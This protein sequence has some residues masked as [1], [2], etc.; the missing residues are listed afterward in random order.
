MR[1]GWSVAV[2]LAACSTGRVEPYT[3]G[4]AGPVDVGTT[5]PNDPIEPGDPPTPV[6]SDDPTDTSAPLVLGTTL[7]ASRQY[8]CA[9]LADGELACWG[10]NDDGQARPPAGDFLSVA[11]AER[12]ACAIAANGGL[13]C[14]GLAEGGRLAPPEGV[15]TALAAGP[16][17]V[18][19]L[20]DDGAPS[21]WGPSA[22]TASPPP[23]NRIAV[24]STFFCGVT[25]TGASVVCAGTGTA[26]TAAPDTGVFK[27][28][29]AGDD[30]VCA[31]EADGSPVCWGANGVGQARP[32]AG[33]FERIFAGGDTSCGI[34]SDG[35]VRCWGRVEEGQDEVPAGVDLASVAPGVDHACGMDTAGDVHCWGRDDRF[36]AT[37]PVLDAEQVSLGLG[38]FGCAVRA[39]G[40]LI[41]FGPATNGQTAPPSGTYVR[42]GVGETHACAV[43]S[44][45]RLACW[46]DDAFGQ[47]TPPGSAGW[48]DVAATKQT[49]CG[50]AGA[51]A[52]VSCWGTRAL[53]A[54]TGAHSWVDGGDFHYVAVKGDGKLSD[55]GAN[56]DGQR[57]EDTNLRFT[58]VSA[59][60][61]NTCGLVTDGSLRCWGFDDAGKNTVPGGTFSDVSTGTRHT[62]A[63]RSNGAVAC[64]GDAAEKA[65]LAPAGVYV[66][67]SA[68]NGVSCAVSDAGRL[69]CWGRN[70]L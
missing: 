20:D 10:A 32:P 24:G 58:R 34:E 33:P 6:D 2:I 13:S 25:V 43:T 59:G 7:D 16:D 69:R 52:G 61:R 54:S 29:A 45:G 40:A 62:C 50:L 27:D 36:Q 1:V 38:S 19:A 49:S 30:H 17:L 28:L 63:V 11:T 22:P 5:L 46:G 37:A 68:G 53:A 15:F 64:W 51:T 18:C 70:A 67:V 47:A 57:N 4:V 66:Q 60:V 48:V 56:G 55:Q 12:H 21:C 8:A 9:L 44:A 42:V 41:C 3:E 35:G 23:L 39:G 14:W 31:L 65:T 26:V